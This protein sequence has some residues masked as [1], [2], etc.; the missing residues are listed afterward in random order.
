[1]ASHIRVSLGK[2]WIELFLSDVT[3]PSGYFYLFGRVC[4]S[5]CVCVGD[6]DTVMTDIT[7]TDIVTIPCE[8]SWHSH[9]CNCTKTIAYQLLTLQMSID[10]LMCVWFMGTGTCQHCRESVFVCVIFTLHAFKVS[11][12]AVYIFINVCCLLCIYSIFI[13]MYYFSVDCHSS[14]PWRALRFSPTC[15]FIK[16]PFQC[17]FLSLLEGS[18]CLAT[19]LILHL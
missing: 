7:V 17:V 11:C 1:M 13:L 4:E 14:S 15:F 6:C 19:T 9:T 12:E 10:V 18:L 2:K 8:V 16:P 3:T 5:E